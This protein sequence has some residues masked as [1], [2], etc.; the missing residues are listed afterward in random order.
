MD[1]SNID[2]QAEN[3]SKKRK[4]KNKYAAPV[5][6]IF[7]ILA[8][9]GFITVIV[10][11]IN[12]TRKLLDN[13]SQLAE[14]ERIIKPVLMFDPVP[15]DKV[16]DADNN[17]LLQSSLWSALLNSE[18][19][20]FV[21]DDTNGMILLPASDIDVACAK[22]FG[23]EIKLQHKTF[24]DYELTYYFDESTKTYQVPLT[25]QVGFYTPQIQSVS[26]KA[27]IITLLVG[28]L[29]PGNL[30][31]TDIQGIEHEPT[32]D[33]Y[34]IYEL[35]QIKGNYYVKAIKDP[36]NGNSANGKS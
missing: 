10:G 28:Y 24:G 29:P 1:N 22:L 25:V 26:K 4:Y 6:S 2:N 27:N 34:M 30:L 21:R 32:P 23:A 17:M 35:E 18:K 15:F 36:P 20:S 13:S 8:I 31:I 19:D 16:E 9:I 14:F 11:S 7:I 5:G 3:K 33:K 12:L